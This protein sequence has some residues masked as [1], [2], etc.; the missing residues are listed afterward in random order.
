M[1]YSFDGIY[2]AGRPIDAIVPLSSAKGLTLQERVERLER[3]LRNAGMHE[4]G[5]RCGSFTGYV[6]DNGY[7]L[8]GHA[9]PCTCWLSEA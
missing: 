1:T 7:P 2:G 8:G 3:I 4:P 5:C 6:D 9:E